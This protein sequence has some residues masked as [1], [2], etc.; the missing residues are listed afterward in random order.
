MAPLSRDHLGPPTPHPDRQSRW[1]A[2]SIVK[3]EGAY[4][5]FLAKKVSKVFSDV[6]P[7]TVAASLDTTKGPSSRFTIKIPVKPA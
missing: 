6:V 3:L 5:G 7:A 1:D 2:T 4:S